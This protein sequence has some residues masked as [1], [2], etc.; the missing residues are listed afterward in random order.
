MPTW[1]QLVSRPN[2]LSF[3]PRS[4]IQLIFF[5]VAGP[6]RNIAPALWTWVTSRFGKTAIPWWHTAFAL[7]QPQSVH[8]ISWQMSRNKL[9]IAFAAAKLDTTKGEQTYDGLGLASG[10][11]CN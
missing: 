6:L 9:R 8:L 4:N 5:L 2:M 3:A 7:Q 1:I 11:H 10:A